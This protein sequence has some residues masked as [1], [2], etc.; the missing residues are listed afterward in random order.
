MGVGSR[1]FTTFLCDACGREIIANEG[2]AVDGYVIEVLQIRNGQQIHTD[3]VFA[4]SESCVGKA[5]NDSLKREVLP[6][7]QKLTATQELWLRGQQFTPAPG[8]P[9]VDMRDETHVIGT[10]Q[11]IRDYKPV[12]K[13]GGASRPRPQDPLDPEWKSG[14]K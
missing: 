10:A 14:I 13:Q 2:A 12:V 1:T 6:D 7:E 5:V 3:N 9:I 8:I 4:C 11:E